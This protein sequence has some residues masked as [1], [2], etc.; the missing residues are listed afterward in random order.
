MPRLLYGL[1][2]TTCVS[3][4]SC[5]PVSAASA[6]GLAQPTV[7]ISDNTEM[8]AILD[9][10]QADREKQPI[11]WNIVAAADEKRQIRTRAL[12]AA[13]QLHTGQDY[14]AASFIFQHGRTS[15]ACLLAHALA[16]VAVGKGNAEA[17]W[18]ASA[19]LDRYLLNVGQKQ[20][21]GTQFSRTGTPGGW[22]QEPYDRTLI[23]DAL[24]QELHVPTL[25]K[26]ADELK[27]YQSLK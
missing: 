16:M 22:T 27:E 23:S 14:L 6:T 21:F 18:I 3:W 5:Q 11:D 15:D 10:D 13:N 19:T 2:F 24:R 8:K 20:I 25:A 7:T 1:I 26:Q 4:A 17:I 9:A 12:L